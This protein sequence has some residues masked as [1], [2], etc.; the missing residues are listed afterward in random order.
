MTIQDF[1]AARNIKYLYHFT[2]L[3]NLQSIL[4]QGLLPRDQCA[5]RQITPLIN[6][7]L[8]LDYTDGICLTIAFPNYK[9]FYP[10]RCNNPGVQWAVVAVRASVLWEKDSAFCRENAAKAAVTAIPLPQRRGLGAL[11]AMYEDFPGVPRNTLGIP[12]QY[13]TNPQAE[14]LVFEHIAPEYIVGVAFNDAALRRQYAAMILPR[15]YEFLDAPRYF[16]ARSDFQHW[17]ANG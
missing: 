3:G 10:L 12:P 14:V 7:Q 2:R 1:A 6:D 4:T 11:Q 15:P 13:P 17:K 8:R 16:S 5:A 9:M